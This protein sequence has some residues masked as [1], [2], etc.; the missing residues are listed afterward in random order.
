[1][2]TTTRNPQE[3]TDVCQDDLIEAVQALQ[4]AKSEAGDDWHNDFAGDIL[5]PFTS[6]L[7]DNEAEDFVADAMFLLN[8]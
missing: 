5:H 2:L 1:M 6:H 3:N 4:A 8:L 7:E